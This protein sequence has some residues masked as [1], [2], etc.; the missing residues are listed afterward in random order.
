VQKRQISVCSPQPLSFKKEIVEEMEQ[1]REVDNDDTKIKLIKKDDIKKN[2]GRSPDHLDNFIMR[3]FFEVERQ[4]VP[5]SR[6]R[7]SPS[8]EL[9]K[10]ISKV[11]SGIKIK[12]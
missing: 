7:G 10:Y 5:S 12:R 4:Y 3:M 6:E 9:R 2:L 8:E 1:L 11:K